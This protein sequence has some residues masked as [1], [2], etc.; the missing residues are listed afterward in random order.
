MK[1][2][3]GL[4]ITDNKSQLITI[5]VLQTKHT[6]RRNYKRKKENNDCPPS[7]ASRNRTG[8]LFITSETLYRL[9]YCG[10]F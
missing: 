7:A 6:G 8:D 10:V 2:N 1:E 3:K 4:Q 9:S 5:A